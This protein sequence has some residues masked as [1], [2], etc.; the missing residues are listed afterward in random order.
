MKSFEQDALGVLVTGEKRRLLSEGTLADVLGSFGAVAVITFAEWAHVAHAGLLLWVCGMVPLLCLQ[1]VFPRLLRQL[2]DTQFLNAYAWLAVVLGLA[3]ASCVLLATSSDFTYEAFLVLALCVVFTAGSVFNAH[4]LPVLYGYQVAGMGTLAVIYAMRGGTIDWSISAGFAILMWTLIGYGRAFHR[5]FVR[6]IELGFENAQ[7]VEELT[8]KTRALE[9]ANM[10]KTR[11]L[12]SASHDLRQPLHALSLLVGLLGERPLDGGAKAVVSSISQSAE[13][14]ESL[15]NAILDLSRLDAGVEHPRM[16]TLQLADILGRI[17]RDF[18]P[19]AAANGLALRVRGH[20][21]WV[22]SDLTM[23]TRMLDNLVSNALRYTRSGGVLVNTRRRGDSIV[24]EVWDTGIG[25]PP[26][27][28][29]EVFQEFVQLHNP[30]RDRSKGLGLG[31]SI[32]RRTAVLLGHQIEVASRPGR[33]SVFRLVLPRRTAP[34]LATLV[35]PSASTSSIQ[36]LSVLVIDD[37]QPIRFALEGLLLAWGCE[38]IVVARDG[39]DAFA[40]LEQARRIPDAILCD[41]RFATETGVELIGRLHA[42][43]GREIPALLVTG[44]VTAAQLR[45]IADSNLPVMHKPVSP[46]ALRGWLSE[47]SVTLAAS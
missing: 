47:V 45:N 42:A 36:G 20:Q 33:G 6:A 4:H 24:I 46:A 44:D 37:E 22:E 5:G 7:L 1:L 3:W 30:E 31:L 23:L 11:F 2:S 18:T 29:D 32:V 13:A 12:A 34:A 14:M 17:E 28:L 26:D 27:R 39:A 41:Y 25:I 19:L 8:A 43:F 10:A 16:E 15:L 35:Q 9:Q 21:H 40:Q 38:D